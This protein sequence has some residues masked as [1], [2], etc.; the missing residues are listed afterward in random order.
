MNKQEAYQ[1]LGIEKGDT[2]KDIRRKYHRLMHKYHP[3]VVEQSEDNGM[4]VTDESRSETRKEMATKLNEAFAVLKRAGFASPKENLFDWGMHD[5]PKAFCKRR[6]YMEDQLFGDEITIDTGG[7]GKYYWEPDLESFSMFLKSVGKAVD[8]LLEQIH[9]EFVE[10]NGEDAHDQIYDLAELRMKA[11]VKLLHLLIQE[12]VDP[13]EVIRE[14]Y[15]YSEDSVRKICRF[16]IKCVLRYQEKC[17]NE[18]EFKYEVHP[19]FS[20]LYA[21]EENNAIGQIQF[22]EDALYYLVNPILT[23]N[24]GQAEFVGDDL[25]IDRRRKVP[26]LKGRLY[27]TVQY[28]RKKDMTNSINKEIKN[29]LEKYRNHLEKQNDLC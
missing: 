14:L 5:N 13:F 17:C 7:A 12:F 27:L 2:P 25:V 16:S 1:L 22:E 4:L 19:S 23:Q 21:L 20:R 24:A 8:G 11:K 29:I 26:Y 15:P 18:K 3:D 9:E 28:D 10:A 6:V